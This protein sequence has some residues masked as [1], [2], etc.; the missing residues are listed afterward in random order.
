MLWIVAEMERFS[1]DS[2]TIVI[3]VAEGNT[4]LIPCTPPAS[5]PTAIVS[6]ELNGSPID[7]SSGEPNCTMIGT[8]MLRD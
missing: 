4:A 7:M 2:T 8:A 1:A 6:F 3:N 5:V